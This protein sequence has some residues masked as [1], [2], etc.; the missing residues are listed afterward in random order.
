[1]RELKFRIWV[2]D[3]ERY[4]D[5]SD[6]ESYQII[7]NGQVV[8]TS[9]VYEED[10]VFYTDT[11]N[12]TDNVIIEQYTGLKDKNGKEIYEGDILGD[13]WGGGYIA[14]CDKCKQL[15]YHISTHEC[16][17]CLGDV[18]WYELVNDNGK[19]EVIGNIHE[20]QDLL[21]DTNVTDIP[22]IKDEKIRKAVRAWADVNSIK[23]ILYD[24]RLC[25]ESC[26]LTEMDGNHN[27]IDFVGW[28]PTLKDGEEYTIA[29][30]CGE[31][32]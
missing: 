16:M 3:E 15:Q 25:K 32:A 12:A 20:N 2:K 17:A 4:Y 23:K 27:D 21:G 30:L 26:T 19:L 5:E 28:I 1:M 13:M 6:D 10:G 9:E 24:E 31:E 22:L 8:Y 14:W 11:T 29:E 7:P 18:Q